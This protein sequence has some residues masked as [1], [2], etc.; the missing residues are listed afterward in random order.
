VAR[1][2]NMLNSTM[3]GQCWT[4][5]N[6]N[7]ASTSFNGVAKRFPLRIQQCWTV[8]NRTVEFVCPQ[9][10]VLGICWPVSCFVS[11][12]WRWF[13]RLDW[14]VSMQP[15]LRTW[16]DIEA[17]NLFQSQALRW[18]KRLFEPW[19]GVWTAL[20]PTGWVSRCVLRDCPVNC[21]ES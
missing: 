5:L 8:L 11:F 17:Q 2:V 6:E 15:K 9:R 12:S 3:L 20:V 18:R 14:L 16:R 10:K 1:R 7:V 13:Y 4:V 21:Y 19:T